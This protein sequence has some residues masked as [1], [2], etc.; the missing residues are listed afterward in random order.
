VLRR[1]LLEHIPIRNLRVIFESLITWAPKEPDDTI[2]LVEQ[3]RVDLKRMITDRYC[4]A[5]RN[6][7]AILFEQSLQ[8]RV[9]SAIQKTQQGVFLGL[10]RDVKDN[11]CEQTRVVIES[12]R[13]TERAARVAVLV[14]MA[15]RF[16]VKSILEPVL[17][18]LPVLSYQEIEED[19]RLQTIGW[20]KNPA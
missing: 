16:Y 18:E 11:V 10:A 1:L 12:L 5:S 14:P 9:Q 6:L 2:A 13:G 19:V 4:G 7:E 3:V 17:P 15:V 20:V 8:D